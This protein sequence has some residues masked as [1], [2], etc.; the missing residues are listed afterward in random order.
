MSVGIL[1]DNGPLEM[2]VF[3]LV[4]GLLYGVLASAAAAKPRREVQDLLGEIS[5]DQYPTVFRAARRGPVPTDPATRTAARKLAGHDLVQA[6]IGTFIAL[7][8]AA[9]MIAATVVGR[10]PESPWFAVLSALTAAVTAYQVYLWRTF[11]RRIESLAL[12]D[13]FV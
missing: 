3:G 11:K 2:I 10:D 6:R 12:T 5:R 13:D 9:L 8:F 4:G 7:P 1:S